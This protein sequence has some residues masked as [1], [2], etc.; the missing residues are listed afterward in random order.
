VYDDTV[1]TLEKLKHRYPE[2]GLISNT[3]FPGWVH[4]RELKQFGIA[5]FLNF[6]VYSSSFGLRKPHPDIFR[7]AA[8]L[9]GHAP[10]ECLYVGDRY[11]ED[12]VGPRG[13]GMHAI[14][15]VKPDREYPEEMPEVDRRIDNLSELAEHIRL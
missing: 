1:E 2:M 14:L 13:V 8:N 5:P 7:K 4:E 12:I 11:V 10:Q 3:I 9:A 6:T 15:K